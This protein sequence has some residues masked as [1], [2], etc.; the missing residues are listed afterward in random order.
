MPEE[1]EKEFSILCTGK[2]T[3]TNSSELINGESGV[4]HKIDVFMTPRKERSVIGPAPVTD[5]LT[6]KNFSKTAL[7]QKLNHCTEQVN[8]ECIDNGGL[9][10]TLVASIKEFE[11]GINQ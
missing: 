4:K 5:M 10:T 9:S 7:P 11:Q 8:Q 3:F 6:I 1:W 2:G